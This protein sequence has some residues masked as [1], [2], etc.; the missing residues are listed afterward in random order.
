RNDAI[1]YGFQAGDRLRSAVD[2]AN[3]TISDNYDGLDR[4]IRE[5]ARDQL[6]E[7]LA[8]VG[9]LCHVG[10]RAD[11]LSERAGPRVRRSRPPT[12]KWLSEMSGSRHLRH[13]AGVELT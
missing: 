7:L 10:F 6:R 9:W 12:R 11:C 5:L 13:G 1:T 8:V 3:G 4:C 2:S